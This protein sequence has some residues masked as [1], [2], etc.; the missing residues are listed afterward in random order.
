MIQHGT[1]CFI[2][3]VAGGMKELNYAM[4]LNI[5]VK[6]VYCHISNFNLKLSQIFF[7]IILSFLSWFLSM[8]VS[9]ICPTW[10]M[11]FMLVAK[12]ADPS[13]F[14][15]RNYTYKKKNFP[16]KPQKFSFSFTM[17]GF[18]CENLLKFKP[19]LLFHILCKIPRSRKQAGNFFSVFKIHILMSW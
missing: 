4:H 17:V 12:C 8:S 3:G 6:S 5:Y 11:Y 2:C 13:F 14:Y 1:K 9:L 16:L 18:I 7:L 19:S 15:K 10:Q